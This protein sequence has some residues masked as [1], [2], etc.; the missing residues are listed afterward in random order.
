MKLPMLIDLDGVL[1]LGK[2]IAPFA[3]EFLSFIKSADIN[4]CILSNSTL[5]TSADVKIFF[6]QNGIYLEIPVMTAS[7]AAAVY[8]R[9]RYKKISVYCADNVKAIFSEMIDDQNP[10]AVVIGDYGKK[11]DF[12][13]LNGIFKKVFAGAG[14]ITMQKNRY[15]KTAE[16]GLL[17]D[18][19]SFVAAIEYATNKEAV[20]IGKPSPLYFQSALR[21]LGCEPNQKFIMIGDD[22][23]T[24]IRGAK[25][26]G[27]LTILIYTGKTEYPIDQISSIKPDHEVKNFKDVISILKN[28]SAEKF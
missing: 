25:K 14:L 22:L 17:M 12:E 10:E 1:R 18:A 7:D 2:T 26:L 20:L 16:D 11:W 6:E 5:S 24:D 27:A 28:I 13:T 9:E 4:G 19:G 8:C 23:E 21:L 3:K 15:W